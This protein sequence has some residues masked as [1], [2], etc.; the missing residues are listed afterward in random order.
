MTVGFNSIMDSN[1][2]FEVRML[3]EASQFYSMRVQSVPRYKHI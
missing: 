2:N 3:I 1:L